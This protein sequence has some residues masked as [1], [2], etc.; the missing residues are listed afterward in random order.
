MAGSMARR[1]GAEPSR[2]II[3]PPP[4]RSL[5]AFALENEIEGCVRETFGTLTGMYQA[6]FA[7]D[8]RIAAMMSVIARDEARHAAL[9]QR[10]STWARRMLSTQQVHSL[11]SA[12]DAAFARAQN[13][14][15]HAPLTAWQ[16]AL[17]LPTA[18]A[19]RALL[20]ALHVPLAAAA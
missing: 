7:E 3:E 8:A 2:A 10:V 15:L 12:R 16:R 11:D 14:F 13:D 9:S 6:R 5:F 20:D 4:H 18:D 17:G 1:F 19:S